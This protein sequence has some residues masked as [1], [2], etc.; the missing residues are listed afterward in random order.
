MPFENPSD[1]DIRAILS[2]PMRI[3]VVGLSADPR[4]DSHRVAAF[5]LA[6][7][8]DVVP[9]NP[10]CDEVLGRRCYPS[11]RDVP[12]AIDMV[13]VFRPSQHVAAIVEEAIAV[14]APIV[15]TQLGVADETAAERARAH[16]IT[17]VMDRCPAN[18]YGRLF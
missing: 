2:R 4:R 11:L 5:L 7:G 18:E 8:H 16:G 1:D 17:V 10:S 15:W 6:R 9:V 12:G 14:R 13:E 3:A